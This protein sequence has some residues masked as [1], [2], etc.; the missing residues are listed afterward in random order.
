MPIAYSKDV[1]VRLQGALVTSQ[2][3][4]QLLNFN[5]PSKKSDQWTSI[6]HT[7]QIIKSFNTDKQEELLTLHSQLHTNSEQQNF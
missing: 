7:F 5:I 3:K 1:S 2:A 4:E 6:V